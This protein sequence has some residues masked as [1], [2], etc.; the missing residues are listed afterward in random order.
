MN[1]RVWLEGQVVDS[2]DATTTL[3]G[4]AA[5]RGISVFEGLMA[6]RQ[7]SCSCYA[8]ISFAS[9]I[10]RL[11]RSAALMRLPIAR[12]KDEVMTGVRSLLVD[13][14]AEQVYL[15][16]TVYLTHG[17]Y[18]REAKAG[19][20]ISARV[21]ESLGGRP[22]NCVYSTLRH[23]P[24]TAYPHEAKIG[25]MYALYR[26][27]RIQAI[28]AGADEAILLTTDG[29]VSETPG[30]SVFALKA[31]VAYTPSVE[32]G[33]LPSVTRGTA[34]DL[35]SNRLSCTVV[36]KNLGP[37]FLSSAD[38]VFITGTM[39]E[40]RS[41]QSIN[42]DQIGNGSAPLT[43]LLGEAYLRACRHGTP[44]SPVGTEYF[45]GGGSGS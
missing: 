43:Q 18:G 45:E 3:T 41:V 42:G 33:I 28:E 6:Y 39:D 26:L 8:V 13:E 40:I 21:V 14:T 4:D 27:S 34:I 23:V 10:V 1:V 24:P 32:I 7:P 31:G 20:F 30:A 9:H 12:L 17:Y 19:L 25:A 16:P 44:A 38:E 22:L 2:S 29:L 15:R 5:L 37:D 36:E 35:L 11:H